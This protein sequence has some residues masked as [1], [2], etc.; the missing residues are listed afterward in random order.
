[1]VADAQRSR[2][3]IQKLA[4]TVAGTFVPAV[5]GAALAAFIAW[6]LW[7]PAPAL[8]FALIASVSVVIIAC[9][10]ALGLATPMSI[11]VAVGRGAGV[12][13]L[14]KSAES[15][16][17]MEK[18]GT[19]VVDKTGTLTEGKPRVTSVVAAEGF[20]EDEV[21]RLAASL[22]RSSEHPLAAAIVLAAREKNLATEEP[23]GFASANGK[24]VSGTVGGRAVV[25]GN[26]RLMADQKVGTGGLAAQAEALRA[27][28]ATALFVSVGGTAAGML[29][30]ADP[31]KASTRAAL[32]SLRADGIKVVMLTGD[33]RAPHRPW[34]RN[35]G[36]AMSRPKCCRRT[37]T[38]SSSVC[39]RRERSWPWRATAS[40][41]PLRSR[42]PM[43]ASPW[44]RARRSRSRAPA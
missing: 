23:A 11:M 22:E 12:G 42:K 16:E 5:L 26:D 21:L 27:S 41:T 35:S 37:S 43:W 29:A 36:S 39:G 7:G 38:A 1:M 32:D 9:P 10:C 28:A 15:L 2:A 18:V 25:L 17:R 24:G 44:G 30:I 40:T 20:S 19:L 8:A 31:I 34:P 3:P 33:T 13:V 4:D 6:A 14:I